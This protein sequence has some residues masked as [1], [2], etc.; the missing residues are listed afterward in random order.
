MALQ[1][2][3]IDDK[4]I[5]LREDEAIP[6]VGQRIFAN[7]PHGALLQVRRDF[8]GGAGPD[9]GAKLGD[10]AILPNAHASADDIRAAGFAVAE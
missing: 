4:Y 7:T 3:K 1:V 8:E 5:V 2:Y 10:I 9:C 6:A